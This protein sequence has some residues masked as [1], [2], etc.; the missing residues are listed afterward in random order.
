VISRRRLLHGAA[1]MAAAA[2][3]PR[4]ALAQVTD[5]GRAAMAGA[6]TALLGALPDEARRR[7]VIAFGDKERFNWHYVPRGAGPRSRHACA[8]RGGARA[9]EGEPSAVGWQ[10]GDDPSKACCASSGDVRRACA[11][12]RTIG[13]GLRAPG[14]TV[15]G[16]GG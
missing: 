10:G 5:A 9:D 2:M 15:R 4:P 8:A 11:I 16:A 13:H 12:P 7:A 1:A 3:S 6:A 14:A